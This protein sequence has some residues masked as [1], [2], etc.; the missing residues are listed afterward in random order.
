M[1]AFDT[2]SKAW[3]ESK[4]QSRRMLVRDV[5]RLAKLQDVFAAQAQHA[6]LIVLQ[7]MDTAGKDGIIKHVMSGINPQGVDVYGFRQPTE[8]E[9]RHDFLWRSAK[10]LPARG[11]IAIFNRSYYE[12]VLVV[13]VQPD[14]LGEES[15]KVVP[16]LWQQR[17][18][19]INAF[20]RHLSRSGTITLK[21]FLHLSWEE[22]RK[23]LLA[24]LEKP[25]KMWKLS[26]ADLQTHHRWNAYAAAY[27]E[28]IANTSTLWA[29]WYVVPSD[30]KW[31]ARAVVGTI[32]NETLESLALS[33]PEPPPDKLRRYA[34]IVHQLKAEASSEPPP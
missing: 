8:E 10:V 18:E 28:A 26:D 31:V 12:E 17:Y 15:T 23:R 19:D 32:L 33:Y 16:D 1:S 34:E 22:Q 20:E 30:R 27:C 3:L 13:R 6:V 14:L 11:R 24:R 29:P 7:G 25:K 21:F 9:D 2:R 5:E 4:E